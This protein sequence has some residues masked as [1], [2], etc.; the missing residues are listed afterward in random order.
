ML[1]IYT[2]MLKILFNKTMHYNFYLKTIISL[3][4][5]APLFICM[6][7]PFPFGLTKIKRNISPSFAAL[8]Y[9]I[10]G[11]FST[12]GV[13]LSL[14]LSVYYGFTFTFYLGVVFYLSGLHNYT[15]R[16]KQTKK[17]IPFS[18]QDHSRCQTS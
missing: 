5:L 14:L 3:L 15:V 2:P 9:G 11:A 1:I 4:S 6:G 10:N 8:V 17:T 18:R 13:I 7:V 12:V 16:K